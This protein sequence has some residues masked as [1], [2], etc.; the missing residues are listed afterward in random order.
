MQVM[1]AKVKTVKLA[2]LNF[3]KLFNMER[4]SEL[5]AKDVIAYIRKDV[6]PNP[7]VPVIIDTKLK[8]IAVQELEECLIFGKA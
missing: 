5:C 1:D 7:W 3:P 2:S 8:P 4:S 6:E